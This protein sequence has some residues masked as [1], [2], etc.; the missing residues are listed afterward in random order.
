MAYANYYCRHLLETSSLGE[1]I[2]EINLY[3]K[4]LYLY[5]ITVIYIVDNSTLCNVIFKQ[6]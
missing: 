3:V 4:S 2:L 5:N 6:F 1:I